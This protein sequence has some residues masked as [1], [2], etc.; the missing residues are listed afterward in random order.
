[1]PYID[2]LEWSDRRLRAPDLYLRF[3]RARGRCIALDRRITERPDA[4]WLGTGDG[5][6]TFIAAFKLGLGD[7]L[8]LTLQHGRTLRLSHGTDHHQH[9]PTRRGTGIEQLLSDDLPRARV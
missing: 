5:A 1:V 6:M 3:A 4:D 8:P 2:T 7:P 9:Q